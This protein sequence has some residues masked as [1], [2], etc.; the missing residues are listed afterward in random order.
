[1]A[2]PLILH[3]TNLSP[4]SHEAL[5]SAIDLTRT[6]GGRLLVLRALAPCEWATKVT[7][8]LRP[9]PG[10]FLQAIYEDLCRRTVRKAT[11]PIEHLLVEGDPTSVILETA[12]DRHCDLIVMGTGRDRGLSRWLFGSVPD[13]V[14]KSAPCPVM[15]VSAHGQQ[16]YPSACVAEKADCA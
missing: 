8:G 13:R 1:M 14:I 9:R 3:P 4:S 5:S 11:F 7:F 2:N 10:A 6:H 12:V 16:I 15:L